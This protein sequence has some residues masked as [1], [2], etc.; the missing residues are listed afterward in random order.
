MGVQE[1]VIG[2]GKNEVEDDGVVVYVE[3]GLG[4]GGWRG[5]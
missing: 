3:V 4:Y 5:D 1:G 2:L